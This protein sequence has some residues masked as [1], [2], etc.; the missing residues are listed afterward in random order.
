M[1]KE[2]L[3]NT[4]TILLA[5]R[6]L[7]KTKQNAISFQLITLLQH[8]S[9][10]FSKIQNLKQQPAK[11][12]QQHYIFQRLSI[13]QQKRS[14]VT[15]AARSWETFSMSNSNH[16]HT[17]IRFP[18]FKLFS[19]FP[20]NIYFMLFLLSPQTKTFHC[21]FTM[22]FLTLQIRRMSHVL[23][24]A[25]NSSNTRGYMTKHFSCI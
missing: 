13:K 21:S 2:M 9:D 16:L 8:K 18:C 6:F 15:A 19:R 10:Y 11:I 22:Y 7:Y 1:Q 14:T 17:L 23:R 24:L 12:F 3:P 25:K 4:A 20:Y 5:S